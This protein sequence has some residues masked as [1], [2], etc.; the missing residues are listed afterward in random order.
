[1]KN[2]VRDGNESGSGFWLTAKRR[3]KGMRVLN[4]C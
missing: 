1:M 4:T 2:G 3:K